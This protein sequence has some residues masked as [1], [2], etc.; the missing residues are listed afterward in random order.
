MAS[1][2]QMVLWAGI[3]A[4][5]MRIEIK[6][7]GLLVVA[8]STKACLRVHNHAPARPVI[9]IPKQVCDAES[10]RDF[11]MFLHNLAEELDSGML[12]TGKD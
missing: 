11:A 3:S 10:C 6:D 8:G 4:T 1:A 5:N 7:D 12:P 2:T 9:T